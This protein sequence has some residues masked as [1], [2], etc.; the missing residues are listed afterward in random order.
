MRDASGRLVWVNKFYAKAVEAA[1]ET[2]ALRRGAELLE[3]AAREAVLRA[4]STS[5]TFAGRVPVVVGTA[6]RILDVIDTPST[7]GSAGLAIDVTDLETMRNDLGRQ[8]DAHAR[9]LDQ[10]AAAVA[11]FDK[12]RRLTFYNA[13]FRSLWQL[14]PAFLDDKPTDGELLDRLRAQRKL[15][16]HADFRAWKTR[17]HEAS[18]AIDTKEHWWH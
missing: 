5:Q 7:H 2:D 13:S 16:E 9:T 18:T 8:T 12:D 15:E 6:R 14:D 4:R 10:L 11:I 3:S 17:L 1:D